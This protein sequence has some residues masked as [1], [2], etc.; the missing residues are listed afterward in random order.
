[1]LLDAL[2]SLERD[3]RHPA[4]AIADAL[5]HFIWASMHGVAM[6]SIDGQLGTDPAAADALTVLIVDRVSAAIATGP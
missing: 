2:V 6:L 3:E 4:P 1:M 5:G